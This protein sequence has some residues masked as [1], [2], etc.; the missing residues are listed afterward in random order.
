MMRNGLDVKLYDDHDV[1]FV[2]RYIFQRGTIDN[3]GLAKMVRS[4]CYLPDDVCAFRCYKGELTCYYDFHHTFWGHTFS[5]V[6]VKRGKKER[7]KT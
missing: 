3:D 7:E 1:Y 5:G 4:F 6:R 2:Y